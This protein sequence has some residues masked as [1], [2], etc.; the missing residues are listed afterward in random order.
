MKIQVHDHLK[1]LNIHKMH[2][3]VLR[4]VAAVVANHSQW[5]L[6]SHGSQVKSLVAGKAMPRRILR[7]VEWMIQGTTAICQLHLCA[8]EDH[9]LFEHTLRRASKLEKG[10]ERKTYAEWLRNWGCLVQRK[11]SLRGNLINPYNY[12]KG[13]CV[14]WS[15]SVSFLRC[16][17]RGHKE[18]VSNRTRADLDWVWGR[19]PYWRGRSKM[20]ISCLGKCIVSIPGCTEEILG[21]NTKEH[22]L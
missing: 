18:S 3:K 11:S 5:Y 20:R 22:G 13:G 7:R 21:H 8:R 19:I 10:L 9:E 6:K 2:P 14:F 12:P 17:V 4:E 15:A 16:Q 1:N